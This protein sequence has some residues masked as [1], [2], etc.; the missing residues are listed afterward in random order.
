[1]GIIWRMISIVLAGEYFVYVFCSFRGTAG[2]RVEWYGDR[3]R[4]SAA[5]FVRH[6]ATLGF[7]PRIGGEAQEPPPVTGVIGD[8]AMSVN[9]I[10]IHSG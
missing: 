10:S 5:D 7:V 8:Q 6:T 2:V 4:I 1:M 9:A 3:R